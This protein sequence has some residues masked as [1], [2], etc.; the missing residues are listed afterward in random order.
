MAKSFA[1]YLHT[2]KLILRKGLK[3]CKSQQQNQISNTSMAHKLPKIKTKTKEIICML[4]T[5]N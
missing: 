5:Y 4:S 2:T 3:K 1:S